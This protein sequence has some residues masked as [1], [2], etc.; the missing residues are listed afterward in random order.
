MEYQD[1]GSAV[2]S[3]G[4]EGISIWDVTSASESGRIDQIQLTA[5]RETLVT[6]QI[7]PLYLFFKKMKNRESKSKPQE[8]SGLMNTRVCMSVSLFS[9]FN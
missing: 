2:S 5:M 3:V 1:A 6:A 4:W 8:S 7:C 9:C